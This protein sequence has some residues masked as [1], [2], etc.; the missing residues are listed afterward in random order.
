MKIG[1]GIREVPTDEGRNLKEKRDLGTSRL[2]CPQ[3]GIG[4]AI[5]QL[6]PERNEAQAIPRF[7]R[8]RESRDGVVDGRTGIGGIAAGQ[9][10][11]EVNMLV[12]SRKMNEKIV[13]DGNIVVTVVKIDRNQV[14]IGIDAPADVRVFREEILGG[15]S[16]HAGEAVSA[17]V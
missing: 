15:S 17:G 5:T 1:R 10:L 11:K 13:I 16:R 3:P 4:N 8:S 7:D 6:R 12:L 9:R 2:V 14:R